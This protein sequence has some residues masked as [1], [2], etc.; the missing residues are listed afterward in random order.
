MPLNLTQSVVIALVNKLPKARYYV[1]I[2]NLFLSANLFIYLRQLGHGAIGIARCNYGIFKP[3]VQL[4]VDD[5]AGRNFLW[6]S[7]L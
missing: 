4:K 3:F 7:E 2:D 6:F 5:I 1:F